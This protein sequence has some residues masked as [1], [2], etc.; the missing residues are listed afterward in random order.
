MG[1]KNKNKN[2]PNTPAS[3]E[4]PAKETA[5]KEPTAKESATKEAVNDSKPENKMDAGDGS[6][7]LGTLSYMSDWMSKNLDESELG[8]HSEISNFDTQFLKEFLFDTIPTM[9]NFADNYLAKMSNR[10]VASTKEGVQETQKEVIGAA[11]DNSDLDMLHK[12]KLTGRRLSSTA[13]PC[14]TCGDLIFGLNDYCIKHGGQDEMPTSGEFIVDIDDSK[15]DIT[16]ASNIAARME[17]V[18][19]LRAEMQTAAERFDFKDELSDISKNAA[20]LFQKSHELKELKPW[21]RTQLHHQFCQLD[22]DGDTRIT[23]DDVSAMV[24][25]FDPE[26]FKK[27]DAETLGKKFQRWIEEIHP[28]PDPKKKA[29]GLSLFEYCKAVRNVRQDRRRYAQQV[30]GTAF[31]DLRQ[32]VLSYPTKI[33]RGHLLKRGYAIAVETANSWKKRYFGPVFDKETGKEDMFNLGYYVSEEGVGTAEHDNKKNEM[34]GTI[35]LL[36]VTV[37]DVSPK[38]SIGDTMFGSLKRAGVEMDKQLAFKVTVANGRRY[39]LSSNMDEAGSWLAYFTW[40]KNSYRVSQRWVELWGSRQ[41]E[42][43]TVRDWVQ[44]GQVA[45]KLALGE[46][47]LEKNGV[48]K[49]ELLNN[50]ISRTDKR[51]QSKQIKLDKLLQEWNANYAITDSDKE[52]LKIC[53]LENENVGSSQSKIIA[54][55]KDLIHKQGSYYRVDQEVL[56]GQVGN[57]FK[58]LL[59]MMNSFQSSN[60]FQE[61]VGEGGTF[62]IKWDDVNNAT[63]CAVCGLVF[64]GGKSVRQTLQK[65]NCRCCGRVVCHM[66]ASKKVYL[67]SSDSHERICESCI[68]TGHPPNDRI[69]FSP[70]TVK[71]PAFKQVAKK[72]RKSLVN[73]M[74]ASDAQSTPAAVSDK[75]KKVSNKDSQKDSDKTDN[76]SGGGMAAGLGLGAVAGGAALSGGIGLPDISLDPAKMAADAAAAAEAALP[77]QARCYLKV[78]RCGCNIM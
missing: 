32:V 7:A 6:Q 51:D 13:Q 1:K 42:K 71:A 53:G 17:K 74:E 31:F 76:K 25:R 4:P 10:R 50:R 19:E 12:Q 45:A 8:L 75:D 58:G 3:E 22:I 54:S 48:T 30:S 46:I 72:G 57:S 40:W 49:D 66:C 68:I 65:H 77:W 26:L 52:Y 70:P 67:S 24:K 56:Y 34:K 62:K 23:A 16:S 18:V 5:A 9:D 33:K 14:K 28:D 21:E 35:P 11:H 61:K 38:T 55:I 2:P 37:V 60:K 43:L 36:E 15:T 44:A 78:Q 64:K 47:Y 63:D 69:I 29:L 59:L 39:T 73:V 20:N 41:K 27:F